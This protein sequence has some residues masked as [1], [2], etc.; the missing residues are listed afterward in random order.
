MSYRIAGA[1][2]AIVALGFA[3]LGV[4]CFLFVKPYLYFD[5]KSD[6]HDCQVN[7]RWIA[8]WACYASL[9]AL[10][11]IRYCHMRAAAREPHRR[12]LLI[13]K[14][15]KLLVALGAITFALSIPWIISQGL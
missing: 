14:L 5:P 1:A 15:G 12:D 9:L 3:C 4:Y 13:L 2:L 10:C 11:G 6:L 8:G 7:V